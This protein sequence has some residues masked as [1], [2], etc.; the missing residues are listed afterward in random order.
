MFLPS[1][2]ITNTIN[3]SNDITIAKNLVIVVVVVVVINKI[4]SKNH[5][6]YADIYIVVT[7]T[8]Y[9]VFIVPTLVPAWFQAG[10]RFQLGSRLVPGSF[11]VAS[12]S[13]PCWS[14]VGYM[15]FHLVP[16][17]SSLVP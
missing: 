5:M 7:I 8:Y 15:C 3:S 13:V 1:I 6:N 10:S 12:R 17:W 9:L 2:G 16:A 4:I 14:Q 11:Q